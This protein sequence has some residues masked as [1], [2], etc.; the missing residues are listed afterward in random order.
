MNSLRLAKVTRFVPEAHAA[1]LLFLDDGSRVPMVPVTTPYGSTNTGVAD[2][3]QPDPSPSGEQWDPLDSGS[4]DVIA[5]VG[6]FRDVPL[7]IGFL[8]P[9]VTE[10][11]FTDRNRRVQRHASD[12][13]TTVDDDGNVEVFHPSGTY[14]RIGTDPAHEDL[15]GKDF[16]GK[17]KIDKNTDKAVHVHLSVKNAGQEVS[18]LDLDP[19]GNLAV[20]LA[21]NL[22]AN[23]EG[24]ATATVG[25][26]LTATVTGNTAVNTSGNLTLEA[27]GNITIGAGGNVVVT[28]TRIDLN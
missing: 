16:D 12:V 19:D 4:R 1:D 23:V 18:S 15:T 8:F 11:L 5:V 26:G 20:D 22:T 13:Y 28:G 9:Q 14:F 10:M 2:M 17:W 24:S 25:A 27:G 7:V 21:G 6:F 3:V